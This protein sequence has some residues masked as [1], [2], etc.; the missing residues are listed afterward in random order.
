M[1]SN[2][3]RIGNWVICNGQNFKISAKDLYHISLTT[4]P[5]IVSPIPLTPEILVK[6]GAINK[7]GSTYFIG[8]LKF[9]INAIGK[10]RFH[11]SGKVAYIDYLHTLQNLVQILTNTELTFNN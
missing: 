2:E 11:Y 7:Y 5:L 8:K 6:C 10:V 1:N 3:L 4:T 9:D